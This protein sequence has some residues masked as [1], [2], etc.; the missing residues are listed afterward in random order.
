M[1]TLGIINS[2]KDF[3]FMSP[4]SIHLRK[5]ERGEI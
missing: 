2:A 4:S 5:L 1:E 3:R